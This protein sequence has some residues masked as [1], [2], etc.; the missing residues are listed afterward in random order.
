MS[1]YDGYDSSLWSLCAFVQKKNTDPTNREKIRDDT[2]LSLY[3]GWPPKKRT[4]N[5][6]QIWP[7][8]LIPWDR[9]TS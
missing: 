5:V 4:V 2:A 3:T 8:L 1:L 9:V 6:D 7:N